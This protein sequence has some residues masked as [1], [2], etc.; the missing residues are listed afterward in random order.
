MSISINHESLS[1]P[2]I[3]HRE[4]DVWGYCNPDFGGGGASSYD[5]AVELAQDLLISAFEL[6]VETGKEFP[7]PTDATDID[8]DGG[9]VKWFPVNI[10]R[11]T[12]SAEKTISVLP[13]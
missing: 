4:G 5:E 7:K 1:Y 2:V 9:Y 3:F 13:V 10:T 11:S 12:K 8:A 6:C